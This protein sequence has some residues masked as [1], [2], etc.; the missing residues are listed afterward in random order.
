MQREPPKGLEGAASPQ[1]CCISSHSQITWLNTSLEYTR[2]WD[3]RWEKGSTALHV[4]A[5]ARSVRP[6]DDATEVRPLGALLRLLGDSG[7]GAAAAAGA[8]A[9]KPRR[10]RRRPPR[11]APSSPPPRRR[12]RSDRRWWVRAR[13]RRGVA[14]E[15]KVS[16]VPER[17]RAGGAAAAAGAHRQLLLRLRQ[18]RRRARRRRRLAGGAAATGARGKRVVAGVAPP[19]GASG[20]SSTGDGR[21]TASEPAIGRG[22][23][24]GGWAKRRA[25]A[26]GRRGGRA[27][28]ETAAES[29]GRA[30]VAALRQAA[31]AAVA[32]LRPQLRAHLLRL[33]EP[34]PPVAHAVVGAL[35]AAP[36]SSTTASQSRRR[37]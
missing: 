13:P 8:Q 32:V 6:V 19:V 15:G 37:A 11:G 17:R 30:D 21:A 5:G 18:R 27:R 10:R 16:A 3:A 29:D 31:A 26:G 33:V 7:G 14:L 12:R 36:Q 4:C 35:G 9:A 25:G 22:R 1:L 34:V 28:P 24:A 20:T 23:R 2:A